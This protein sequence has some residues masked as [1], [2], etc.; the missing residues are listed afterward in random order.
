[1]TWAGLDQAARAQCY[2]ARSAGR[3]F[4]IAK[5]LR[6]WLRAPAVAVASYR[7]LWRWYGGEGLGIPPPLKYVL[8][9]LSE[10]FVGTW[11]EN[12]PILISVSRS[13]RSPTTEPRRRPCI[14]TLIVSLAHVVSVVRRQSRS[15]W[16]L[17]SIGYANV[18]LLVTGFKIL[19]NT[20]L[21][22]DMWY[23]NYVGFE[24]AIVQ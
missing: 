8:Y 18:T 11:Y 5:W 15:R 9:G 14:V 19:K 22:S 10:I 3:L 13:S 2:S 4:L 23:R 16:F 21:Y 24:R 6:G 1:M 12:G 20:T 17:S 7:R